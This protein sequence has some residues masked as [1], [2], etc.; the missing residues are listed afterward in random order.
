MPALRII[1]PA[2]LTAGLLSI[3]LTLIPQPVSA[4]F[5]MNLFRRRRR[6]VPMHLSTAIA[7]PHSKTSLEY[8]AATD[9][10]MARIRPLAARSRITAC[11][12]ATENSFP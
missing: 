3:A 8:F 5:F 2:L 10:V 11:E 4:Q 12:L 6:L 1:R 9:R 7:P